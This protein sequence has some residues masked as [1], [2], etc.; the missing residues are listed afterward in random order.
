MKTYNKRVWLNPK[1]SYSTGN[2]VTFDGDVT[3]N[4]NTVRSTFLHIADC[5]II[6]KLYKTDNDTMLDFINKLQIIEST[7]SEFKSHL[8]KQNY[9]KIYL[10]NQSQ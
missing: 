1:S 2:L 4:N 8:I 9:E 5:K 3:Y 6:V 10:S 7:I